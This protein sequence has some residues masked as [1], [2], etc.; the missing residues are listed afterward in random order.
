MQ[1]VRLVYVLN[2]V[3]IKFKSNLGYVRCGPTLVAMNLMASYKTDWKFGNDAP[4]NCGPFDMDALKEK[5][6]S[7]GAHR[8]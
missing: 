2:W 8:F 6:V 1:L 3:Q 5:C 4:I 7:S